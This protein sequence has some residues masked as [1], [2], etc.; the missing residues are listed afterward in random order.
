MIA[1]VRDAQK[2]TI[3]RKNI[4]FK[5]VF[6][7]VAQKIVCVL[8]KVLPFGDCNRK[9]PQGKKDA[10]LRGRLASCRSAGKL[11]NLLLF[12]CALLPRKLLPP[13]PRALESEC[14]LLLPPP[15]KLPF[16]LSAFGQ[17]L[18]PPLS[19]G[20]RYNPLTKLKAKKVRLRSGW[21]LL[22]LAPHFRSIALAHFAQIA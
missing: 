15:Q 8:Y 17:F 18:C 3:F 7:I 2:K 16:R 10:S 1:I 21:S 4:F 22:S 11:C 13:A 14:A 12:A 6:S 19:R 9:S 20:H 5:S